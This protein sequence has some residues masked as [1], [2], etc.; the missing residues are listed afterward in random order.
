MHTE[1]TLRSEYSPYNMAAKDS[2]FVKRNINTDE[3]NT[4]WLITFADLMSIM[5]V[6]SFF[7]FIS[8]NKTGQFVHNQIK[9]FETKSFIPLAHANA[10]DYGRI[11]NISIYIPNDN[12]SPVSNKEHEDRI[13]E[14]I[15]IF[16]SSEQSVLKDEFKTQLRRISEIER[17]NQ[18]SKIIVTV[19]GNI[20]SENPIRRSSS[21]IKY[22]SE[23]CHIPKEKIFL[24]TLTCSGN[25]KSLRETPGEGSETN[26][27][28]VKVTKTFWLL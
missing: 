26:L 17:T 1:T 23:T 27:V 9:S 6:F 20:M 25:N 3:D 28:E 4:E 5:L 14:K 16:F 13:I 22:L 10:A 21:V 19:Y 7:M 12:Q 11:S 2:L 18:S 8:S 24:Q 15:R